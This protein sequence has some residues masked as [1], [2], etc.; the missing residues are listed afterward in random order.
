VGESSSRS[1]RSVYARGFR[2]VIL[3]GNREEWGTARSGNGALRRSSESSAGCNGRS[4]WSVSRPPSPG[5]GQDPHVHRAWD[6]N[7]LELITKFVE[8]ERVAK[9][10]APVAAMRADPRS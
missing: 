7:E 1:A 4:L 10:R 6:A 8:V 5:R 2:I 9:H 3:L